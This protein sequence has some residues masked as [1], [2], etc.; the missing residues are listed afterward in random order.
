MFSGHDETKWTG[1]KE[2]VV[3]QHKQK[4]VSTDGN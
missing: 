2:S 1:P 4:D 3:E